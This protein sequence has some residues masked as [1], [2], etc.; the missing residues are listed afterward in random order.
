MKLMTIA[1]WPLR[2]QREQI[3]PALAR[4]FFYLHTQ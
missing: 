2:S 1:D 3:Q 4:I